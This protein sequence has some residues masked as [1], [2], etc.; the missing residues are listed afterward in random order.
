MTQK[1]VE[2]VSSDGMLMRS[3]FKV[4]F[5]LTRRHFFNKNKNDKRAITRRLKAFV[6]KELARKEI[7]KS[8]IKK[9]LIQMVD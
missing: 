9:R 8:K 2:P 6:T 3:S 1:Y 5:E 7:S 4:R